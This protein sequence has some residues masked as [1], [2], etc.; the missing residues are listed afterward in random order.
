MA[1][2]PEYSDFDKANFETLLT[3]EQRQQKKFATNLTD[4]FGV[5]KFVILGTY[6]GT[7]NSDEYNRLSRGLV[8]DQGGMN[9]DI[10]D[11]NG[12]HL[13]LDEDEE[14]TGDSGRLYY[15]FSHITKPPH[16]TEEESE[17]M[18]MRGRIPPRPHEHIIY[19]DAD[20]IGKFYSRD[21]SSVG[22]GRRRKSNGR[23]KTNGRRKSN[24]RRKTN[25]RRKKSNGGRKSNGTRKKSNG[26][27]KTN[28]TRKKSN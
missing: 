13:I 24:G 19:I 16:I 17:R 3:R 1:S 18:L 8:A 26:R 15:K 22:G 2:G 23:R 28:G 27:R 5:K 4:H 21:T 7:T 20:F 11:E 14:I 9:I 25:G 10:F 12:V 6:E